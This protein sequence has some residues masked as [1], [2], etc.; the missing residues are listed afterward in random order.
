MTNT[1]AVVVDRWGWAIQTSIPA[2]LDYPVRSVSQSWYACVRAPLSAS[3]VWN[4][5]TSFQGFYQRFG[6]VPV[7]RW[8]AYEDRRTHEADPCQR[9]VMLCAW[10]RLFAA[11]NLG[12]LALYCVHVLDD[13]ITTRMIPSA[14]SIVSQASIQV[15]CSGQDTRNERRSGRHSMCA[16]EAENHAY[17]R[18]VV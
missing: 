11:G 18:V 16:G 5:L 10:D 14:A 8:V 13:L 2:V 6:R 1:K 4:V 12:S 3:Y 9:E 17:P 7:R 15:R